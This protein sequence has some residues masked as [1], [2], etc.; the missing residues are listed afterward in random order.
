MI[1]PFQS[2]SIRKYKD[3][4]DLLYHYN[5]YMSDGTKFITENFDYSEYKN[6]PYNF[7]TTVTRN[8]TDYDCFKSHVYEHKPH[9]HEDM[10]ESFYK[11][12][13]E[14]KNAA[15]ECANYMT[16]DSRIDRLDLLIFPL[17]YL[18][19]H[20]L[21]LLLKASIIND[22][23]I[24]GIKEKKQ[25][26][27]ELN[28]NHDLGELLGKK[29]EPTVVSNNKHINWL[30]LFLEDFSNF[31]KMSDSFRYPFKMFKDDNKIKIDYVFKE[32]T[33]LNLVLFVNKMEYAFQ[34]I[35]HLYK[36][37]LDELTSDNW[38][39]YSAES[40][41]NGGS[42]YGQSVVGQKYNN[43]E[44]TTYA[45]SYVT[46]AE[47]LFTL[48]IIN[49][50]TIQNKSFFK[51]I[52]YLYQN[53]IELQIKD[54]VMLIFEDQYALN[55]LYTNEKHDIKKLWDHI[56][57]KLKH[58]TISNFY[59][60][61]ISKIEDLFEY[62]SPSD[63]TVP[64]STY[65]YRN[66]VKKTVP[67]STHSFRYPVNKNGQDSFMD[68]KELNF[69]IGYVHHFFNDFFLACSTLFYNHSL[70]LEQLEE[71]KNYYTR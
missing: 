59:S 19:R 24:Q 40:L 41:E 16:E 63:D 25:L 32:Q 14:F 51:P 37:N 70:H 48:T 11:M 69:H 50:K 36:N 23:I 60:N 68:T 22:R 64:K 10:N 57:E 52:C 18:Y 3:I 54:L 62:L 34:I 65:S 28:D 8:Y 56:C 35:D 21:E 26:L 9:K 15:L 27:N 6:F 53:A 66:P 67:I 58:S 45:D 61:E 55:L 38:N 4:S 5:N 1:E 20:S 49:K 47:H 7:L 29:C 2:F 71:M 13:N 39:R 43:A 46:L 42:Y 33:H 31:D 17:A 30:K 12:A 44:L